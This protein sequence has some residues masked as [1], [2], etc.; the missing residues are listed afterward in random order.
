MAAD[1]VIG[2]DLA[3]V[4]QE[5][6]DQLEYEVTLAWGDPVELLGDHPRGSRIGFTRHFRRDD[7]SVEP[8]PFIGVIR[9]PS[10][11]SGLSLDEV[12]VPKEQ[13]A[14]L[15][16]EFVDVQQGDGTVIET[17]KGKVVLLDGGELQL[18]A[19]Y[20]STR[21]PGTSE[22]APREIDAIV[23]SHGD[24]D[25]FAGL[26]EIHESETND[27][28]YKRVFIH[29]QRVF[30]NGLVKRPS[31][32][33]ESQ[34]L[35]P[36][37]PGTDILNGLVDDIVAVPDTEMNGPFREWKAALVAWQQRGPIAMQRLA[38]G[39]DDAFDFL[40]DESVDV[41]VLGPVTVPDP[42]RWGGSRVPGQSQAEHED[43]NRCRDDG[44]E[45][46]HREVRFAHHQRAFGGAADAIRRVP[47]PLRG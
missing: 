31:S 3:N 32:R 12:V 24:A 47:V 20:L 23:V 35:G 15:K 11:A 46:F 33:P 19:R 6:G 21:F 14:I 7:G 18:Y 40:R 22:A 43:R 2:V 44:R 4:Y 37:A 29:P 5:V 39:D 41:E 17:P 45:P 16:V 27:L 8:V 1:H 36:I 13:A 38:L 9:T 26:T 34:Q 10:Q 25:H 30:H 42:R 28:A